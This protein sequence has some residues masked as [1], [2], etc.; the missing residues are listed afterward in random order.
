[1]WLSFGPAVVCLG[2]RL[3]QRR[4]F[5]FGAYPRFEPLEAMVPV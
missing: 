1:M 4:V 5:P 2:E 3:L